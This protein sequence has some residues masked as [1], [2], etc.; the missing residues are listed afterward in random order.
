MYWIIAIISMAVIAVAHNTGF[1]GK[2][3]DV[4]G[5]IAGC[6]MCSCMWG[7]LLVLLLTG[8]RPWEAIALSFLVAYLSNWFGL[9]LEWLAQIYDRIWQQQHRN[10]RQ[11]SINKK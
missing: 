11:R 7:T 5:E 4:C 8:C 6:P 3:Y 1:V 10:R 2:A 9:M